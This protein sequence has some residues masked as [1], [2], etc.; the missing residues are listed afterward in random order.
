MRGKEEAK[1][2]L[3]FFPGKQFHAKQ[4]DRLV[5]VVT[6]DKSVAASTF[7]RE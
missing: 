4:D 2:V 5:S 6:G 1:P 7:S 3:D